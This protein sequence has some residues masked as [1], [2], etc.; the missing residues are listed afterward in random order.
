[1]MTPTWMLRI[2]KEAAQLCACH[3]GGSSR[4]DRRFYNAEGIQILSLAKIGPLVYSS[5]KGFLA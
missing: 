5:V 4:F 3:A 2:M 1:M